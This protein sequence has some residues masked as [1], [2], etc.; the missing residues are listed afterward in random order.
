ML[1]SPRGTDR[2]F[3][4]PYVLRNVL[5]QL[6]AQRDAEQR[7]TA[8]AAAAGAVATV[9]RL[10]LAAD[11]IASATPGGGGASPAAGARASRRGAGDASAVGTE[12]Q[13]FCLADGDVFDGLVSPT[14]ASR[15]VREALR[16][17]ECEGSKFSLVA[18]ESGSWDDEFRKLVGPEIARFAVSREVP[19]DWIR[20][21]ARGLLA[22]KAEGTPAKLPSDFAVFDLPLAQTMAAAKTL[23]V[24]LPTGARIH[25]LASGVEFV[26][27]D[28]AE[29]RFAG[30]FDGALDLL[31]EEGRVR[32]VRSENEPVWRRTLDGGRRQVTPLVKPTSEEIVLKKLAKDLRE[33]FGP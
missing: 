2:T 4:F 6:D 9:M 23:A 14:V 16:R 20:D 26:G 19:I 5:G 31:I 8:A 12:Q 28:E 1:L 25:F 13:G 22:N 30:D 24:G 27:K 17:R 18:G 33:E 11:E 15:A 29:T 7:I 32:V 21:W 10:E 3:T